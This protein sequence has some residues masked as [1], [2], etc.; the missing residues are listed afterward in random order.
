MVD[1]LQ[2]RDFPGVKGVV[3]VSHEGVLEAHSVDGSTDQ[4]AAITTHLSTTAQQVCAVL[5]YEVIDYCL[6]S[7]D[8]GEEP[9]LIF[10]YKSSFIGLIVDITQAIAGMG[11]SAQTFFNKASIA[12]SRTL[13]IIRSTMR[14]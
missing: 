14:N 9:I 3:Q 10:P 5:N 7:S 1:L 11:N 12:A 13:T 8:N 2:L 4:V 6:Y